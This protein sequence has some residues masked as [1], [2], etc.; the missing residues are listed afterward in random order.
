MAKNTKFAGEQPTVGSDK[1]SGVVRKKPATRK[2]PTPRK[3]S[4]DERYRMIAESAYYRAE[5]RGFQGDL[6]LDDW[7][8]AEAEL[9][10]LL[11]KDE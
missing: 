8:R 7:L 1:G 10:A 5:Q 6:A 11:S 9:D 3:C 4:D 2:G